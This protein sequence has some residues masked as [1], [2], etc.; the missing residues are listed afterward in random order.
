[1]Y[2][3]NSLTILNHSVKAALL[4]RF[5]DLLE[6]EG[7][8]DPFNELGALVTMK[9]IP[10]F[11]LRTRQR[12]MVPNIEEYFKAVEKGIENHLTEYYLLGG[13]NG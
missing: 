3:G 5:P 6:V 2:H 1:M 11:Y 8:M 7:I 12:A 4:K 10:A 13:N 9:D